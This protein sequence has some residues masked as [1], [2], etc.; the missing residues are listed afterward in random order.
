MDIHEVDDNNPFDE[1]N[2]E[3]RAR[4]E[5]LHAQVMSQVWLIREELY[6]PGDERTQF[7]RRSD[8][9]H[10]DTWY[11]GNWEWEEKATM[12]RDHHQ[13]RIERETY[14]LEKG[15]VSLQC[16]SYVRAAACGATRIAR[17]A[18]EI[19]RQAG[20]GN[21]KASIYIYC[22]S[23]PETWV[24]QGQFEVCTCIPSICQ[25]TLL[26][27]WTMALGDGTVRPMRGLR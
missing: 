3:E 26:C 22:F 27:R 12:I 7:R 20:N 17:Q 1:L 4:R 15:L 16:I 2:P 19:A 24:M 10:R 6:N 14:T 11:R 5:Q 18:M 13:Y 23:V 21:S 8:A 25:H 9:H